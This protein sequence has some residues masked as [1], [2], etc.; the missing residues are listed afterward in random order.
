M[1]SMLPL[2]NTE[3]ELVNNNNKLVRIRVDLGPNSMY[4]ALSK[5]LSDL[6]IMGFKDDKP[7]NISEWMNKLS[8]IPLSKLVTKLNISVVILNP[9]MEVIVKYEVGD[10]YVILLNI[11]SH[12]ECIGLYENNKIR[13]ILSKHEIKF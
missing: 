9:M 2:Y 5:A 4:H 7:I 11:N 1:L 13:T 3:F 12:Y 8:R 10:K 6:Y